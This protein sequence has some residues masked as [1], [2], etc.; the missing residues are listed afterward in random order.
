VAEIYLNRAE[1]LIRRYKVNGQSGDLSQ[2]LSD[3]NIL[4][5]SRYDKRNVSYVPV[6]I[7]DADSLFRFCQQERRRELCLEENHR[8]VDIKRW[9]LSITH[10]YIDASGTATKYTLASGSPVY[11][12]PIPYTAIDNNASLAQN[13]R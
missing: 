9:G 2:A 8:W 3:L 5:A 6:A 4:R 12:L 11:A 10:N 1:A 7:S 13:P